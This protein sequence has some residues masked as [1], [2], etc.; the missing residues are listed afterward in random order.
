VHNLPRPGSSVRKRWRLSP[1]GFIIIA[2]LLTL[3]IA[4]W[5]R[6]RSDAGLT[7]LERMI[8]AS[9]PAEY[10]H[11]VGAGQGGMVHVG[12]NLGLISGSTKSG[13]TRLPGLRANVQ[14][15][16]P[17]GEERFILALGPDGLGRYVGGKLQKLLS[18]PVSAVAV[19]SH[20][21][22]HLLAYG[23]GTGL[24]AS[25]NGG[26]TWKNLGPFDKNEL[27]ALAIHP[28]QEGVLAVGGL[29]GF[30]A[31][32]DDGGA[33]WRYPVSLGRSI[34]ALTFD[35]LHP[36]RLW[37]AAGGS[38]LRSEDRGATWRS[39]PLPVKDRIVVGLAL[40]SDGR[41]TLWAI[42]SEGLLFTVNN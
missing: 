37:A 41:G 35:P 14:G 22:Q 2:G 19:N 11:T 3:S 17:T 30:L 13:W 31:L 16:V 42:T 8:A 26:V 4:L 39:I 36:E 1:A 34:S 28:T 40:V 20:N 21:E 32:S 9:D 10:V 18:G 5:A 15:V 25:S 38:V 23:A 12:T 24:L 33:S 7:V 27:L 29:Q 6:S